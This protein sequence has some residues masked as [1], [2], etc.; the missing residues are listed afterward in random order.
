VGIGREVAD[1][2]IDVHGDLS[3]FRRDLGGA[4]DEMR[5]AAFEAADQF[6]EA[7]QKRITSDVKGK[8]GSIVDAMYSNKQI[9]WDRMIGEFDSKNLDDARKQITGFL[10]EM[11]NTHTFAEDDEG[12][13]IDLGPQLDP[14]QF[15]IM[16]GRL[17]EVVAG[18]QKKA[19]IEDATAKK[20]ADHQ[21]TLIGLQQELTAWQDRE[22][23]AMKVRAEA[24]EEAHR[25]NAAWMDRRKKTMEDAIELNKAWARTF[26]GISKNDAIKNLNEDFTKLTKAMT[27]ADIAKWGN[28]LEGDFQRMAQRVREV[29]SAMLE[30]RRISDEDA[31]AM[32]NRVDAFIKAEN[33]KS[34]A[35]R[36]ALDETNRLTAAQDKYNQSLRGMAQAFH[37]SD[38]ET[39]FRQ[40]A[41]AIESNDWSGMAR[42]AKNMEELRDR[43]MET[44]T[45]MHRLGRMSDGELKMVADR[46]EKVSQN[47]ER[48][49][50]QFREGTKEVNRF[51]TTMRNVLTVTNN[52][53]TRLSNITRG[54]R[55]HLG[56]FAGLN[57]FGD[58]LDRG[59]DFVHNLDRIAL[60]LGKNTL[61]MGSMA[62]V[63][64][65]AF[66]G[67]I[68][69]ASDLAGVLGGAAV[70]LPAFAVGA[71]I[72]L[73]VL[74]AAMKDM[75]T[76]LADLKP[77]F[78]EL[79][80]QISSSFWTV[81]AAPIRE[82]VKTLMPILTPKLKGTATA[83]GGLVGK[84]A[85]AFKDIPADALNTMFDRMNKAIDIL[86][87]AMP[88]LVRAFTTLG[89]VGSKYFERFTTWMVELS[90]QFDD[91]I[92]KAAASGQ[93]DRW[94]NNMIEGFK[95]IGRA[96]DG[97]LGIFN[98]INTAAE[99]AGFG[100]LKS[101]ADA[102]QNAA[103][104]MQ[105]PAF[106]TTLTTYLD[107]ARDLAIKLGDAIK[108]LGPA[109]ESFA[110]TANRALNSVG[111]AVSKIIGYI[112][113]I[114]SN[115]KFQKGVEDFTKG[116]DTAIGKLEPAIKP[117]ADSLGHA[118]SLLGQIAVSVAEVASAF[119]VTLSPVLDSMSAKF[120][121]LIDPL[122]NTV[123]NFIK[124]ME[125]PLRALEEQFVGPLVD[126]FK[127]NLLPA[128]NGFIDEFG[129]FAEK[130]IKDLGP[131]FKILVTDALPAF[132]RLATE[133]L[134][135]L[136][137]IIQLLSPTLA[138]TL[139]KIATAF[140]NLADGVRVLKGELPI[141]ELAIFKAMEPA[142]IQ[143][144]AEDVRRQVEY[145]M[146]PRN[147]GNVAWGEIISDI[148]WGEDVLS[149]WSKVYN[150]IGPTQA[151]L[152]NL[153]TKIE[154]VRQRV[155]DDWN[156]IWSGRADREL[157]DKVIEWFPDSADFLNGIN[158]WID[159]VFTGKWFDEVRVNVVTMWNDTWK[160]GGGADQLD[161][162]VNAWLDT[163]IGQPFKTA[164][165]NFVKAIPE[166]FLSDASEWGLLP[167]ITNWF[168]NEIAPEIGKGFTEGWKNIAEGRWGSTPEGAAKWEGFWRQWNEFWAA[169]AALATQIDESVNRWFEESIFTPLRQAWD[170]AWQAVSDWLSGGGG[171]E[172]SGRSDANGQAFWQSFWGGFGG[173]MG[174]VGAWAEGINAT[175][176]NWLETNVWTPIRTWVEN[177][178]WNQIGADLWNG[179]IQGLTGKDVGA[180]EKI[181]QG[182]TGWVEDLKTFFGIHSPSTLMFGFAADIV[183][184]F[185]NGFGD[186]AAGVAAKWEEIKTAVI[187]AFEGIK[188]ALATKY[189]EFKVGWGE[190]WGGLGTGIATKWEEIKTTV[191]TKWEEL[192]A[193]A[194]AAWESF[195]IAWDTFW[196][197]FGSTLGTKWEEFKTTVTT[198]FEELKTGV[199]T[200]WEG[201]KTG[202]DTF[203]GGLG[204]TLGTKWEE[205]KTT[206]GTKAGEI[207]TGVDTWAGQVKTGWDGF[208]GGVGKT[209]TEKWGEFTNTTSTK[210]GEIKTNVSNFGTDVKR[211]WDGFWGGVGTTLTQKWGEFTGTV[212]TQSGT[213][214]GDVRSM[215]TDMTGQTQSA[216]AQ[217]WN[218]LSS[219][220]MNFVSLVMNKTRDIMG[221]IRAL[222]G[223]ISGALNGLSYL[224]VSAGASIMNGFLS[225]LRSAW[226]AVTNFVSG[227]A[228]WI[229]N[230]KGPISYDRVLLQPAGEA[231]MKG[232]DNG[233]RAGMDPLLN[234]LQTITA[235]VT[236][237][238]TA[239]LSKSVMYATGKDAAQGL[240]DGLKANRTSV[241]TALG[242]LGA[243]A[244][245]SANITVGGTFAAVGRPSADAAPGRSVTIAEGAIKIETPT[246]SPELVAAKLID[247][248]VNYSTY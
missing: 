140:N 89:L 100:G 22:A 126:G 213:M 237:S 76:V 118:L 134:E 77:A 227:I 110:P 25:D 158:G 55:E 156:D 68:T 239:D 155:V 121:T 92:Q 212:S 222:P 223:Q 200:A 207:K 59:L 169:D 231:I 190:F 177:L 27:D 139:E 132:V 186:F 82:M 42:G 152:D 14:K 71:G 235:A 248:F 161:A 225:G 201:L 106:Q 215:G 109:F 136:G 64:V 2:Y 141:M 150:K 245:P 72:S 112:G 16:I 124:E 111:D 49:N 179:F 62:A 195:R 183:A 243:F 137:K 217:M 119:I 8:W 10:R 234:T 33:E 242:N 153:S 80:N 107:G 65:S 99:R 191:S 57:V 135:P 202:W 174:D 26:D 13:L 180:W 173:M 61:L 28:R 90:N 117:F 157:V 115:P 101:F 162:S 187:T 6:S 18:M 163:H 43:T 47:M 88:P 56:G 86:G 17:H 103:A 36:D 32:V 219:S 102:L 50:V 151:G 122:K 53:F 226:G 197:G 63:G 216:M 181:G 198:K 93:L 238:V 114:F 66:A 23:R 105:S 113:D 75:K 232:L 70:A 142:A 51:G 144:Q 236:D 74:V 188:T 210:A 54:F 38:M 67:L 19:A 165:D 244:A 127:N 205:F 11:R 9:D 176:N 199:T 247:S 129:P 204:T 208:W 78:A 20:A 240:A 230:N 24:E 39:K 12:G 15:D 185:L 35:M 178:D 37:G 133:L 108:D 87:N 192:R 34:K 91:F 125:G 241:H 170:T 97:T 220:F 58:L 31:L 120:G 128:I 81:A 30:Q 3:S 182:F 149:F 214:K 130:V 138:T 116:L 172:S 46:I 1:A 164:V 104:I 154:E 211:N 123:I 159:D 146:D 96:I 29:S 95:D 4:E 48:A 41:A 94:I 98:A 228:T 189:E 167:A 45:E 224:L 145:N 171:G 229:R 83:L 160:D 233:I 79:Q 221:Y 196:G 203:W 7:W 246:K 5:A 175:V 166:K 206:V 209:L 60:G 148:F 194:A 40:L 85:T 143:K 131:A 184:G 147:A 84:L 73:G 52:L 44:A 218:Y 168:N 21:R 69:V 193:S